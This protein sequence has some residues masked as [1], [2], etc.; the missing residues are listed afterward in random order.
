M[1]IGF[2]ASFAV[3][4]S[5]SPVDNTGLAWPRYT[6][7]ASQIVVFGNE[8]S[9]KLEKGAVAMSSIYPMDDCYSKQWP[10]FG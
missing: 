9:A 3:D 10:Q 5:K 2:W 4:S 6:G 8:T 1:R 7:N